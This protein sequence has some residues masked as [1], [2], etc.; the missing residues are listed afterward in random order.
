M[1]EFTLQEEKSELKVRILE[2]Q[3]KF[4]LVG[5]K[6]EAISHESPT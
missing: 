5:A 1:H 6:R 4:Y 3:G 2:T